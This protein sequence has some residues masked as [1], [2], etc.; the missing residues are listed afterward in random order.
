MLKY[1]QI[2]DIRDFGLCERDVASLKDESTFDAWS[3]L[4]LVAL[5]R[6]SGGGC[7]AKASPIIPR[8]SPRETRP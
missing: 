2:V 4:A 7:P 1:V 8:S 5:Y 6:K 3:L